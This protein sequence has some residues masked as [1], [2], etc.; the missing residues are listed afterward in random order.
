MS[1]PLLASLPAVLVTAFLVSFAT[2]VVPSPI[3][4]AASR[5]AV[6]RGTRAAAVL[7]TAVTLTDVAVFALIAFGFQPYLHRLGGVHYLIPVAGGLLVVAGVAM[8]AASR[9]DVAQ[10]VSPRGRRRVDHE[11][12]L[13]GSFLAGV[14]VAVLNP[15]YWLWWTTAGT[16]FIHAA[17]HWG[18]LGL[19]LA[20]LAFL[21]GVLAWY[22]PLVFALR[23]GRRVFSA[24]WNRRVLVLL[25]SGMVACGVYVLW[26][27][28]AGH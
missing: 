28:L 23:H 8:V 5:F 20:L 21:A 6:A 18:R 27:V 9:R 3:T 16:T 2:V 11:Q 13:H 14:A 10:L 26:R 24:E 19:A 4:L 25:G 7:L 15:G 17:R 12:S 22:V 1:G